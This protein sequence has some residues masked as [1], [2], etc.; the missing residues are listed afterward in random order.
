[1]VGEAAV[2]PEAAAAAVELRR[3]RVEVCRT[4]ADDDVGGVRCSG[5]EFDAAGATS[6]ATPSRERRRTGVETRRTRRGGLR[7]FCCDG[8]GGRVTTPTSTVGNA[9]VGRAAVARDA[10]AAALLARTRDLVGGAARE[11]A[12]AGAARG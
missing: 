6:G 5:T 7:A 11:R 3:A 4:R 12:G 9:A 1:T 2:A 10:A 8:W